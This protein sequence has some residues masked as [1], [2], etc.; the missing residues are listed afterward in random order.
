M[1]SA[2][3]HGRDAALTLLLTDGEVP[4]LGPNGREQSKCDLFAC[5]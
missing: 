2:A 4:S 3:L 1:H 5:Y